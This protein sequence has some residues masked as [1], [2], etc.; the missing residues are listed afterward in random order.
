VLLNGPDLTLTQLKLPQVAQDSNEEAIY[1]RMFLYGEM[2]FIL[3]SLWMDF[4]NQRST[5]SWA[6]DV[7]PRIQEWL[8][9]A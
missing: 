3:K 9:G 1:D 6:V 7:L 5:A 2:C 8:E 4:A